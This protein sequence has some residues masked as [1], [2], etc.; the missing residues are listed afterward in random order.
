[1]EYP[2]TERPLKGLRRVRPWTAARKKLWHDLEAARRH[3][4]SLL[5]APAFPLFCALVGERVGKT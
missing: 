5:S 2:C 4:S 1:M 3:W